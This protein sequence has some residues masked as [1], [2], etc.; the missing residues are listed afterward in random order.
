MNDTR[1]LA[2]IRCANRTSENW[3]DA[4]EMWDIL[5]TWHSLAENLTC[6]MGKL[7]TSR[8]PL[9]H[10]LLAVEVTWTSCHISETPWAELRVRSK[11]GAA[12]KVERAR[13]LQRE[14]GLL[15]SCIFLPVHT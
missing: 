10:A 8:S 5:G 6:T 13:S 4:W 14:T 1:P 3:E 12:S 7:G 11:L 15:C 2:T 9:L